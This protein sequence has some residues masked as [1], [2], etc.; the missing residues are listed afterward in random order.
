MGQLGRFLARILLGINLIVALFLLLSVYSSLID[1]RIHPIWSCA[2]YFFPIFLLLNLL[3]LIF[4][5][6][7][8]RKFVFLPLLALV[9]CW[10]SIQT[11]IPINWKE[12][13]NT[14]QTI[15][16]LS[17]NT[18]AFGEKQAH[19]KTKPNDVLAY[20]Q[21]CDADI[22]CI[23]EYI[24]GDALKRKDIDF[25]LKGYRYKHYLS[26][27]KGLNGLGCYSR[28]PI[29]SAKPIKYKSN[30]NGSVAYY[31]KV[32]KDT[33]LVVNNHLESNK[34][35]ESDVETYQ[36]MID[37]PS[38]T[39]LLSGS[40]K[41]L[42]KLGEANAIRA[43]QTDIILNEVKESPMKHVVV[44]GDFNDIPL[45]YT[46]QK[47]N[48]ELKDAFTEAGNGIGITYNQHRLYFRIDHILVSQ[49][50]NVYECEVDDTFNASDH[51]PIWCS[52]SWE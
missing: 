8:Y 32:E 21:R 26:L 5:L 24:W 20:L 23:Q 37:A 40:W 7:A 47:F 18:R 11:Y 3:F 9:L 31:I 14:K 45:S 48:D 36:D 15:K 35:L 28:Y 10:D 4:W 51:Y 29:L 49:D 25:A 42:R 38:R 6:F 17:Y 52:I 13:T 22:I 33:L 46:H 30:R 43:D 34:I 50:I 44:C 27:G 2:G 19:T 41:L 39:K 12:D 16:I 1:P